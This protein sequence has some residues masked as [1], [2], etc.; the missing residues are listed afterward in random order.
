MRTL[1]PR[2]S[3]RAGH[4]ALLCGCLPL[5]AAG[6]CKWTEFDSLE[7]DTWVTATTKPKDGATNWGVAIARV[8]QSGSGGT[9][10]VLGASDAFYNDLTVA[11]DGAIESTKPFDLNP[12]FAIG[13][14]AIDPLL[15]S[16]PTGD[17]AALV[18]GLDP[19]RVAVIRAIGGQLSMIP[20]A[21]PAQPSA[22]T[23]MVSPPPGPQM[24]ILVAERDTVYGAYFDPAK[25]PNPQTKCALR[26]DTMGTPTIRALGAYRPTGVMSDDVLALSE[27]GK[28]MAYPGT[29][30][31]GCGAVTQPPKANMV[32][33]IGFTGAQTGSQIHVFAD[34]TGT[35][36]VVQ[37]HNSDG[38][39]RGRLGV[40]RI[41]AASIAEVGTARDL[42][43]V[44]T[45]ALL[46]LDGKVFVI[47]G[48]PTAVVDGV[49]AGQVQVLEVSTTAGI[50]S[51]PALTL[52]DARPEDDQAFG[53]GVAA[54]P[55]NG[56]N[57]I[58][59]GADSEVFVY[60]R[61]TLYAET[62]QGR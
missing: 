37:A 45:S 25:Q 56:K 53:R 17:E 52:N 31:L 23:Y 30:F 12:Q 26:D 4:L 62:R 35:Y 2:P 43:R 48:M 18:T 8:T 60:F 44:K 5:L 59:V 16:N 50:A 49:I 1:K 33:D 21:G 40:Y 55:F 19:S 22:A 61:T 14:L 24:Q 57:I 20:V 34:T 54:L 7:E 28:L 38:T 36:A 11:A 42:D 15:L 9:L 3:P 10:A 29:V 58:A 13:N 27:S 46:Q 6:A 41:D 39:G 32:K 51:A 47:V